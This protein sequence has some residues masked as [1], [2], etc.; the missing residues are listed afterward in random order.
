MLGSHVQK[1]IQGRVEITFNVYRP[2]T[3][4]WGK[5]M[6]L[7]VSVCPRRGVS[8]WCHFLSYCLVPS[9]VVSVPDP[10][11]LPGGICP[12]DV[13][14]GLVSVQGGL[15]RGV[16]VCVL[17]ECFLALDLKLLGTFVWNWTS[18]TKLVSVLTAPTASIMCVLKSYDF[19][20]IVGWGGRELIVYYSVFGS[21]II[22]FKLGKSYIS[23]TDSYGEIDI[24]KIISDKK[25]L[26]ILSRISPA[27]TCLCKIFWN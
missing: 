14:P 10:M 23:K 18:A 9:R 5:V 22:S 4:F 24:Y 19:P 26:I 2:Q 6:F 3:K 13:C 1:C 16:S 7:Q 17:G 8:V 27:F 12:G 25:V 11:F 15:Y 21:W 20:I